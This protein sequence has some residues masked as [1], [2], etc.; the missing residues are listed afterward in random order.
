MPMSRENA[1]TCLMDQFDGDIEEV[2]SQLHHHGYDRFSEREEN[3]LHTAV[4]LGREVIDIRLELGNKV[5]MEIVT[6]SREHSE[7]GNYNAVKFAQLF[8]E[9]LA[10]IIRGYR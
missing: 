7:C 3:E 8:V 10:K 2:N 1:I 6:W 5:P 9:N 4:E